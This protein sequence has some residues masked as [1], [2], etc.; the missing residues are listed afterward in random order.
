ML[1][2]T[3]KSILLNKITY[4]GKRIVRIS[5]DDSNCVVIQVHFDHILY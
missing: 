5:E 2:S 4:L 3:L 1:D